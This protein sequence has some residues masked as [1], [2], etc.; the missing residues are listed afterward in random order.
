MVAAIKKICLLFLLVMFAHGF[1]AVGLCAESKVE[2]K[3]AAPKPEILTADVFV[4][5]QAGYNTYRIPSVVVTKSGTVLA[6]CEGRKNGRS[7]SGNIGLRTRFTMW[8]LH[9]S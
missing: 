2:K 8:Y 5:G 9:S 6:F 7:D 1:F 3:P 4:S